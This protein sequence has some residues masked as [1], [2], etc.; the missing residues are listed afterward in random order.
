MTVRKLCMAVGISSGSVSVYS[1]VTG[2]TCVCLCVCVCV[3]VCSVCDTVYVRACVC[4][5]MVVYMCPLSESMSVTLL[6]TFVRFLHSLRL[7]Y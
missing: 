1:S 5:F 6:V 3:C 2:C 7:Q 4:V